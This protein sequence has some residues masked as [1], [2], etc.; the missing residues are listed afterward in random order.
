[1]FAFTFSTEKTTNSRLLTDVEKKMFV[2]SIA[3]P[4]ELMDENRVFLGAA[5]ISANLSL[6]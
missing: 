5:L 2:V 3:Y 1:M 4:F 6:K